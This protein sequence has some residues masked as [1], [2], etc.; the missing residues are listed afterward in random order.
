MDFADQLGFDGVCL[1]EHHQTA[2]GMMPIPG[3]ARRRARALGQ[4]RKL[5]ISAARCRSST[6]R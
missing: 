3:R 1:N 4:A 2:Y 5:A 6:I